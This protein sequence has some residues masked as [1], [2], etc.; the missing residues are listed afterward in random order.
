VPKVER[1]AVVVVTREFKRVEF[2]QTVA[3]VVALAA[4]LFAS[5]VVN[6]ATL[7]P[8]SVDLMYHNYDGGGMKING[9]S[10]LVRKSI[11]TQVSV[12]G[13]YYI[14]SISA[15]SVDV[16]ASGASEY[17]EERTETSG[18]I[19]FLYEK[20][21]LS[22]GYTNSSENDYE[23]NTAY[24]GVSQDFFGDLTSLSLGYA[25]GWD[26][27]GKRDQDRNT[28]EEVNRQNYKLGVTQVLTK[29]AIIGLDVDVITDEGKLENPYRTNRYID[30]LG[31][32]WQ[33]ERYPDTRTS[34]AFGLR[35]MYYLP[36]RA[37]IKAEYRYF[38]DSWKIN[39]HTY[40]LA[41]SHAFEENWIFEFSYRLYTQE[42]AEFYS[43]LF[44]FENSQTHL[45]RDKELS[46]YNGTTMG[47]GVS[48]EIKQ[49]VIP[50][51]KR[52]QFSLLA[53]YLDYRYDNFR[54]VT[55]EGNYAPGAEPLYQ[56]DAWV[57]RT[58]LI[59]EF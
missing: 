33:E 11:G 4:T 51:V 54:D 15:A 31:V 10:V 7:P 53:D 46:S 1:E 55:A 40:D 48:Y 12:T 21:I 34:T 19:D 14:D 38:S 39:S 2:S 47:I 13:H 35:G 44:A 6:S 20:A 52:M 32:L 49:G 9:P 17:E 3:R 5:S 50:F 16:V 58:S 29:N 23:A 41:Y 24:F 18:G 57:T 59:V 26:E 27:V 42:H 28:F 43:D 30:G 22:A 37:S 36:Y 56:F 8:D 45:G 25:R